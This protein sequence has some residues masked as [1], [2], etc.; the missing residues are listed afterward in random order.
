MMFLIIWKN[1]I[2]KKILT[3]TCLLCLFTV[4]FTFASSPAPKE[5]LTFNKLADKL[6]INEF[7]KLNPQSA[8]EMLGRDLTF[9]EKLSLKLYQKKFSR[10]LAKNPSIGNDYRRRNNFLIGLLIGVVVVL[11]II[12]LA[13]RNK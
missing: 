4:E 6:T 8:K 3:L 9:K 2:M 1:K 13:S 11:V 10:Q 7:L 12:I 5:K